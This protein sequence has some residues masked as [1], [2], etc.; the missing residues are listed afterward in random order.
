MSLCEIVAGAI[1][2]A[3]ARKRLRGK[4]PRKG[5]QMAWSL[6]Q[7]KGSTS[8]PYISKPGGCKKG[9]TCVFQTQLKT[10]RFRCKGNCLDFPL[11]F[12]P[13]SG[14][15]FLW[16]QRRPLSG[17]SGLRAESRT[18]PDMI[19]SAPP[20]EERREVRVDRPSRGWKLRMLGFVHCL[21]VAMLASIGYSRDATIAYQ[22]HIVNVGGSVPVLTVISLRWASIFVDDA[23]L[24]R[25]VRSVSTGID[26]DFTPPDGVP[27]DIPIYVSSSV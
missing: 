15:G 27:E 7:D 3:G 12:P 16:F 5:Q 19:G 20:A 22:Q 21:S 6:L 14:F 11:Y 9:A 4:V 18:L 17:L 1:D 25:L 8:C 10:V 24:M 13:R 2:G 26:L 23:V